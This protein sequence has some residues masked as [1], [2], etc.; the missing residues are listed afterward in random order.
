[1][2]IIVSAN[3]G[4]G[5]T[6]AP[7]LCANV[8]RL[9]ESSN[10]TTVQSTTSLTLALGAARSVSHNVLHSSSIIYTCMYSTVYR[11]TLYLYLESYMY[12][13]VCKV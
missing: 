4:F 10:V 1:M 5:L 12:G 11:Y 6:E 8:S 13:T 2:L 3:V 7:A 9:I